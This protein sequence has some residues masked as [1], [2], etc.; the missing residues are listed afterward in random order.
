MNGFS[1]SCSNLEKK[2]LN[3]VI[4]R[5]FSA[6]LKAGD[7]LAVTGRNGSGKSTLLKTIAGLIKPDKGKITFS[8]DGGEI[9]H[10]RHH[11]YAGMIAPYINLYEE[12][13][14][15]EN[16]SFFFDL[17]NPAAKNGKQ[18]RIEHLLNRINLY[19]RR[20]DEVKNFSSGMKQRVKLAFAVINSPPLLLMDEPRTNLDTQG[21]E[22]VYE[23]A[24]EQKKN[25]VLI[26]A[27]NEPDDT[28]LCSRTVS[29]EDYKNT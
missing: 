21:I 3:K 6:E 24:E 14:A 20:N 18:E 28:R 26:V 7:S 22:L 23:V 19:S 11:L 9:N 17:K 16:L 27:T 15:F 2:F 5:N 1:L 12:L 13:T 10:D 4:F 29:I 25:G 8:S